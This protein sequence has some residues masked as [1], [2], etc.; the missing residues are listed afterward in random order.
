MKD[1]PLKPKFGGEY[2]YYPDVF[3]INSSKN[4]IFFIYDDRGCEVIASDLETIQPL[5]EKYRE[6]I[7][8]YDQ[9]KVI[10]CFT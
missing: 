4:I 1:F 5:Y 3:F 7:P 10:A 6:W 2:A 9:E 8:E